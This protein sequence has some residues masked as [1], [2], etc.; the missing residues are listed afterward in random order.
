MN[1]KE[2]FAAVLESFY[3]P[4]D[5]GLFA[6]PIAAAICQL[7]PSL[8]PLGESFRGNLDAARTVASVPYAMTVIAIN[9]RRFQAI[10]AAER[11]RSLKS[12]WNSEAEREQWALRTAHRRFTEEL[13]QPEDWN[14]NPTDLLGNSGRAILIDLEVLLSEVDFG[15]SSDELLRQCTVLCW[16]ALEVLSTDL[17]ITVLNERPSYTSALLD[18]PLTKKYFDPRSFGTALQERRYDLSRCMGEVLVQQHRI[19]SVEAIRNIFDALFLDENDLRTQLRDDLFWRLGQDRNLIVH[20]RAVIDQQYLTN[21][22]CGQAVGSRLRI[23]P[24][25]FER[26]LNYSRDTG[27]SLLRAAASSRT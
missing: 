15:E 16:G 6:K 18:H 8:S 17:F 19:D 20:R 25:P 26:Y 7:P 13:A 4:Q 21:T 11:I 10:L 2:R 22:G 5:A 9:R 1:D 27:V 23:G 12:N 24:D 14:A 3:F